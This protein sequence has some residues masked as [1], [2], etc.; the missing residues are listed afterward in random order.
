MPLTTTTANMVL[1]S[2]PRL[3]ARLPSIIAYTNG[4]R[5]LEE[6]RLQKEKED[7]EE[8]AR[9]KEA[10]MNHEDQGKLC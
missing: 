1:S 6:K 5:I 8:A 9:Q 2:T 3:P 7:A 10:N 4:L